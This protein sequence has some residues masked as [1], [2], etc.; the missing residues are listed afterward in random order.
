MASSHTHATDRQISNRARTHPHDAP[1]FETPVPKDVCASVQGQVLCCVTGPAF[2][3]MLQQDD[4]LVVETV[5][6]N[7]VVFARMRS[8]QKGQVMDLLG[9]RG[10]HQVFKDQPRHVP[11]STVIDSSNKT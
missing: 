7:V 10:L 6:R 5:M 8:H 3:H 9:G 4:L 2:Q 11:V 1:H